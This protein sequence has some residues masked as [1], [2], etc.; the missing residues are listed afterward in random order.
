MHGYFVTLPLE[1]HKFQ[2]AKKSALYTW[3]TSAS[4]RF[5]CFL[6]H[7]QDLKPQITSFLSFLD[8]ST[9]CLQTFCYGIIHF[10]LKSKVMLG[11]NNY[12]RRKFSYF[13]LTAFLCG[14]TCFWS[15]T[16]CQDSTTAPMSKDKYYSESF[17]LD[18]S[19]KNYQ[20]VIIIPSH[21]L[22]VSAESL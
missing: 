16:T 4:W 2:Y 18:T 11:C 1:W 7:W 5:F 6:F 12:T 13:M 3:R 8:N 20:V 19:D 21:P 15:V 22:L 9:L 10:F 17:F 14:C